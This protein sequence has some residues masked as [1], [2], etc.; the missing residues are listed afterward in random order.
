MSVRQDVKVSRLS[1]GRIFPQL[2]REPGLN[3]R[4]EPATHTAQVTRTYR[5]K[6]FSWALAGLLMACAAENPATPQVPA[7]LTIVSG[8]DQVDSIGA[9]LA[10]SLVV[11]VM[12]ASGT[13][14]GMVPVAWRAEGGFVYPETTATDPSGIARS[15]WTLGLDP[16]RARAIASVP[17]IAFTDT[18][19]ATVQAG[20]G[21][22]ILLVRQGPAW[23][24]PSD[25][26]GILASV[27]DRVGNPVPSTAI[28]WSSSDPLVATVSGAGPGHPPL[29]PG[30]V[31]VVIHAVAAGR[32]N[33]V[34]RSGDARD[35]VGVTVVRDT[36][37]YGG[38][39]L[40]RRDSVAYPYCQYPAPIEV[41][42]FSGSLTID[43]VG[44]FVAKTFVIVTLI[45]IN[46]TLIDSSVTTG[47]YQ[48]IS[49]CELQLAASG[50]PNGHALK[51]GALLNVT[52]D[53]AAPAQHA[54]VY[55][56]GS[57]L[58]TCP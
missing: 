9:I 30:Q 8:N 37:V 32:A 39:D 27:N 16:G 3:R 31:Q 50:E 53:P 18:F 56:G 57:R 52:T 15:R 48:A 7:A 21:V 4:R 2:T 5:L 41:D 23:I 1:P 38:Y 10:E 14:L 22:R 42:C 54:W 25:S 29:A 35:S 12:S 33:V 11:R 46:Q 58:Q 24:I 40:E 44:G 47:T 19:S 45:P 49:T 17:G 13:A 43:G 36:A 51:S 26:L 55:R 28:Q 34:G 20:R 6:L